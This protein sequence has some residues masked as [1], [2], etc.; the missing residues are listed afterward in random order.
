MEKRKDKITLQRI[1]LIHPKLRDEVR[2][3]YDE[4]CDRLTGNA[5]A[6]FTY[7]LRTFAEQNE[8]YS[9]GRT[10][11][12]KIV[13]Y[14]RGGQ[15]YH[16]FGMAID[17]CLLVDKNNDWVFE[18]VSWDTKR[19]FDGDSNPEWREVVEVFKMYGWKWGGDFKSFKDYPHFE[20]SLGFSTPELKRMYESGKVDKNNYVLI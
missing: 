12:G 9:R 17:F 8:L 16:N 11:S 18:E 3:M 13:T 20:K 5:M 2:E 10:K 19:D 14:A 4:I 15:S 1:E 6:R 7:T